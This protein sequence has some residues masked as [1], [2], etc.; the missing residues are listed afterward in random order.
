MS[1]QAKKIA[2][3]TFSNHQHDTDFGNARG[4][5]NYFDKAI[6]NQ[7]NRLVGLHSISQTDLTTITEEDLAEGE[8]TFSSNKTSIGFK[9]NF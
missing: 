6:L 9:T 8:P 2:K 3:D 5:R 1:E 4:V 7:A